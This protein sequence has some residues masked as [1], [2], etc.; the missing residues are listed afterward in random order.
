VDGIAFG[1]QQSSHESSHHG[2]VIHDQYLATVSY[3]LPAA[4]QVFVSSVHLNDSD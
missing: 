2:L 3:P 1:L 4:R